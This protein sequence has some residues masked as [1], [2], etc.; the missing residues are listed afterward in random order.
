MKFDDSW[1]IEN[2]HHLLQPCLHPANEPRYAHIAR[3]VLESSRLTGGVERH[4]E[5]A[6][7]R[8]APRH[9]GATRAHM[10]FYRAAL[11]VIGFLPSDAIVNSA[12]QIEWLWYTTPFKSFYRDHL[13]HVMKVA[14]TGLELLESP[15]SPF[16]KTNEP[17]IVSVARE[18][19]A[20]NKGS[21]TLRKAARRCGNREEEIKTE[22]FWRC[23]ILE[24]VRIAGLLHD[25]AYPDVMAA[26]VE[27]AARP[28]RP[29]ASFE[30]TVDETCRHAVAMFQH[31]LLASPFHQGELP[32]PD[33][34]TKRAQDIAA[35]VF[36]KSHSLR[37]GYAMLQMLDDARRSGPVTAFDAFVMEWAALATSMH[38]YY[39]FYE[40]KYVDED[41]LAWLDT[42][43]PKNPNRSFI[44]P[45]YQTDPASFIVALA[46]QLQDFGRMSYD[47]GVLTQPDFAS[48]R[49]RYPCR[50]A[51]IEMSGATCTITF[52]LDDMKGDSSFGPANENEIRKFAKIKHDEPAFKG[53][54]KETAWL[55]PGTLYTNVNIRVV[56][57]GKAH[58][59]KGEIAS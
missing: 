21:A 50:A 39:K 55:R 8:L 7:S 26:S 52:E 40:Q 9:R 47:G 22:S 48:S 10:Q 24:T 14:L 1:F 12:V 54:D 3:S 25:V 59:A 38:D 36:L 5:I 44:R 2:R 16:A 53:T 32:G 31:H 42:D 15:D 11:E 29:R 6:L 46:D 37:G 58:D 27:S 28:V 4:T 57:G 17:L 45:S 23:A 18:L 41:L 33:G 13:A 30:P 35:K 43:T 19:A 49:V 20:G 56:H 34:I 51:I